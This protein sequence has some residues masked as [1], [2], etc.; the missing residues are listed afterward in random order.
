L[1]GLKKLLEAVLPQFVFN[2]LKRKHQEN[3]FVKWQKNGRPL[4]PPHLVKQL[5][6]RDY[7][8][9]YA[10][11]TLVETGT[12]RGDMVQAQKHNFEKIISIELG[13]D[14]SK[15]AV[16]RF[17]QDKNV[18][19]VQG[20]SGK[21]LPRIMPTIES[22]TIFWLDGHYS[23]GITAKGEKDCPIFAEL[24]AIFEGQKLNHVLLIDDARCFNGEGDYPAINEL[25]RY[26]KNKN[27]DYK[28]EVK[29]DIIR[30]TVDGGR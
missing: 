29:D 26:I 5:A 4:P 27:A 15:K 10:I 21:V 30:Y 16:K 23:A 13:V 24:D 28:L 1:E 3:Q 14:L 12:Y 11:K 8:Q 20:D 2:Y 7:Q 17:K 6:I 9:Q 22:P 18:S 19:I 25:T